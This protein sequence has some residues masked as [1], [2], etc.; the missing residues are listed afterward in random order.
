MRLLFL[1]HRLPY[2]PNRGDRIRAHHLLRAFAPHMAID[3]VSLGHGAAEAG[4]AHDLDHLVSSTTVVRVPRGRNLMRAGL[5]LAG[6]TPLTHTLLDSPDLVPAIRRVVSAHPPDVVFAYCSGMAQFLF[7]PELRDRP[8]VLDMV[9]LDSEKWAALAASTAAP[10]SWIYARE[11]R[12][13]RRFEARACRR[14]AVTLT[15]S[16]HERA[17][18]AAVAPG[19]RV[20]CVP[21]GIDYAAFRPSGDP[22]T[23]PVVVFCGVMNYDPNVQGVQWLVR[24]V[25]PLVRA[26]CADAQLL[27]VGSDPV[28]QVT[29]LQDDSITV[30]GAVPDVRPYLWRA[31]VGVAPLLVAR[32]LQNKV[33]E[34]LAAGLPT[35]VTPAVARGLPADVLRGCRT[36][37]D[38]AGFAAALVRLLRL[39]P[40]ARRATAS[41]AGV[42]RL[43]WSSQLAPAV[44]LVRACVSDAP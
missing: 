6:R 22:G 42:E 9:D 12:V 4:H 43:D 25:W 20:V 18:T 3:L 26:A 19:S 31:A 29:Q 16:E 23:D 8:A 21:N 36:A 41:L 11:A 24:E 13:L 1:T 30:T 35:V 40:E 33:L 7:L 44:A 38:A 39:S 28:P 15:V 14:A 37:E 5:S 10:R 27:I 32:G 17:A 2:A 34:A